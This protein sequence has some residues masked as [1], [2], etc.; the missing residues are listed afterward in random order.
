[1][2]HGLLTLP[3][4][5]AATAGT[6]RVLV[7]LGARGAALMRLHGPLPPPSHPPPPPHHP[8]PPPSQP[9]PPPSPTIHVTHLPAQP[10]GAIV[11]LS[12]AGDTLVGGLAAALVCGCSDVEAVA[13][14]VAAAARAVQSEHNVPPELDE[15]GGLAALRADARALVARA[16]TCLCACRADAGAVG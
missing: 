14:G 1:M 5:T 2:A 16:H 8:P 10:V 6:Q 4:P 15:G 12:G 7:T 9:L 11:N 3:P 13:H